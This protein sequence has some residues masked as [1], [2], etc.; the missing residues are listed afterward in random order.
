VLAPLVRLLQNAGELLAGRPTTPAAAGSLL[1]AHLRVLGTGGL[2]GMALAGIDMALW[3]IEAQIAGRSLARILGGNRT[4]V[5]AYAGLRSMQPEAAATETIEEVSQ[6]FEAV[7][8]KLGAGSLDDDLAVI[9]RIRAAAGDGVQIMADY[10]QSL[11]VE[12]AIRRGK[13][14]DGEGLT[15]IE[16]PVR[17]SDDPG[18]ARISRALQTPVQIGE[19]WWGVDEMERSV[20]LTSSDYVTLDAVRI[21]GVSGWR[22]AACIAGGADLPVSSHRYPEASA[23]LLAATPAA[24]WLEYVDTVS[25]VLSHPLVVQRG[26]ALVPSGPGLGL[27]W[28]EAAVE[29]VLVD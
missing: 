3:D 5:P 17:A 11:T 4:T 9:R 23:S 13:V 18:H 1:L 15:W 25:P 28:D 21:G 7:K 14:L 26:H 16:E 10:N 29:R 19:N 27:E 24:H 8:V 22:L 12:E 2:V 20:A 6:G